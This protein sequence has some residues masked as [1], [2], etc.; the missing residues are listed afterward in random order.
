MYTKYIQK[1]D[2]AA[3]DDAE[4]YDLVMPMYNFIEYSWNYSDTTGSLCFIQ[5][6][7]QL[8]L[9]L[10]LRIIIIL[11]ISSIRLNY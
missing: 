6:M 4:D 1:I 10:I 7:E 9:M 8:I 11:N 2:G 5:K 3:I